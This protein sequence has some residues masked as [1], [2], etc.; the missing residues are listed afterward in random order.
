MRRLIKQQKIQCR[1]RRAVKLA[2]AAALL[3]LL[4]LPAVKLALPLGEVSAADADTDDENDQALQIVATIFPQYNW[5]MEL[6]GDNPGG[7]QV[8][9]LA[10][11]GLDLHSYQPSVDDMLQIA[12]CD[13]FIYVG[14]ESDKWVEDALKNS[15]NPDRI[16]VSLMEVLGENAREEETVP[17]MQNHEDQEKDPDLSDKAGE[18]EDREYDEHVWLSVKN[19]SLFCNAI[20]EA[21]CSADP[22]NA[23]VYRTNLENYQEKLDSLDRAYEETVSQSPGKTLLFGDRF[24]FLYL[25][26]DYGLS[27]YAA[28]AGCSA[29]TE[30]SFETIIFLAGKMDELSLPCVL[31]IDGSDERIA[32]TIIQNTKQKDRKI[33]VMNSMQSVTEEDLKNGVSYLSV[34]EQN[35]AVLKEALL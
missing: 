2:F 9:V 27:Y 24:P 4:F 17:G 26:D 8:S 33:L 22:G 30:A 1:N 19:A 11:N 20:T 16:V 10:G 5:T 12:S 21:L 31:I 3:V 18:T 34:M 14:G 7:A 32:G 35:L 25:T 13:L 28:F 15:S 23:E 29:E 6:L